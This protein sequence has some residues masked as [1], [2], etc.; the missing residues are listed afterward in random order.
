MLLQL[1][2]P[3]LLA[4]FLSQAALAADADSHSPSSRPNINPC[5]LG[6]PC[7]SVMARHLGIPTAPR[8][9]ARCWL[10][11]I[12]TLG[13]SHADSARK[14]NRTL[15]PVRIFRVSSVLV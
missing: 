13:K 11:A 5:R 9:T 1:R 15:T 12:R 3:L 14:K 4:F 7:T 2:Y 6:T 8:S 10:C